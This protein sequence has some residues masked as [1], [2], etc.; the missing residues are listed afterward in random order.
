MVDDFDA[1]GG[2][3]E[4]QALAELVQDGV[5][6]VLGHIVGDDRRHRVALEGKDAAFEE[7]EVVVG[8]EVV[9]VRHCPACGLLED[10]FADVARDLLD[11]VLEL[12]HDG[13]AFECFDPEAAGW[14]RG[15]DK[16][17]DGDGRAHVLEPR[18]QS[19]R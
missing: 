18:I 19:C 6:S 8:E 10:P 9:G 13:L 4:Q 11:R 3:V 14:G 17:D 2:P 15:D 12:F 1:V 7:D 5:F 16:G